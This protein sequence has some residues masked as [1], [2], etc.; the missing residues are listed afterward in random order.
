MLKRLVRLM[1]GSRF[2]GDDIGKQT[3]GR[4][5]NSGQSAIEDISGRCRIDVIGGSRVT[6][7]VD[8]LSKLSW[9]GIMNIDGRPY[10][11][12]KF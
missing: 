6:A 8:R 7:S 5:R 2:D 4:R 1:T 11:S 3:L 9:D 12:L 10:S